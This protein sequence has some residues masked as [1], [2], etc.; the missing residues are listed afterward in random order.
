MRRSQI[1][2]AAAI[3]LVS[4]VLAAAQLHEHL[5]PASPSTARAAAS[6][7]SS[8]SGGEAASG[9]A[10][11]TQASRGSG[12]VG[13]QFTGT[14]FAVTGWRPP[15]NA[16][17][18]GWPA[19]FAIYARAAEAAASL[20]AG[21][22]QGTGAVTGLPPLLGSYAV[23]QGTLVFRPRF[24]LAAGLEYHVVFSPPGGPDLERTFY[25]PPRDI[26]PST[27]VVHIY[28][29]AAVLPS[30]TLRLYIY[31]SAPMSRGEAAA[32]VHVL[33]GRGRELHGV[34]LPGEELW[35]PQFERLTLTFDPGRIKRGLTSNERMGP[36]IARGADYTLVIDRAWPD[37]RGA[38]L[39]Q[40]A[41]KSYRGGQALRLPP[42]PRQWRLAAPAAGKSAPLTIDFPTPM[43]YPLLL[44]MLR[45]V[46]PRGTVAGSVRVDNDETRW[47][48]TPHAAWS[49]GRYRIIVNRDLEDVA[50]NHIGQL[51]DID[52]FH[53]VTERIV[54][55]TI[56]LP[57][58]VR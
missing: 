47:G 52:E 41:R 34:F 15:A 31:F 5:A 50:G 6:A 13:I 55:H 39:L 23:E 26:T 38:P 29:S 45:V 17:P 12:A 2:S 54:T 19:I 7:D 44:R 46:G 49:A 9:L 4:G 3:I 48:F 24:P 57:F 11:G 10:S 35:D 32:Y 20:G 51:F 53:R 28:P 1:L 43:N 14:R 27:R 21:R 25:G 22:A 8:P 30:N 40:G 18:G 36:P 58:T 16:P 42:D 37:A 56:S 33:D